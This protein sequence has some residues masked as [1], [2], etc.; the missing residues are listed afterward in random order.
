MS[1]FDYWKIVKWV[2]IV[3]LAGFIGQF[4]KSLAKYF[5]AHGGK[6]KKRDASPE[7]WQSDVEFMHEGQSEDALAT[8]NAERETLNVIEDAAKSRKKTLKTL[9]KVKKKETK[10]QEKKRA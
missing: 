3:L 2:L 5:M 8:K 10:N 4:G 6:I 7:R 1:D 9:A